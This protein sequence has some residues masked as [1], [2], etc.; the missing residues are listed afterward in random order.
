MSLSEIVFHVQDPQAHPIAGAL[1]SASSVH[2]PWQGLTDA[3]GN[4]VAHLTAGHYVITI[5]ASGF[6]TRVLPA[7]LAD[8]G[9]ITIGLEYATGMLSPLHA[10]R[11]EFFTADG[12]RH[13]IVGSTELML[14]WRFDREGADA[15]RDVLE[16]RRNCGFNNLR[17]LW[18]KGLGSNNLTAS[19][20]MPLG[21]L[22]PFLALAAE[23][24]FYI[25]GVILAD[26]QVVNPAWNEQNDRVNAVRGA[27]TG[28]TNNI[29]ELGNEF[30]KNGFDPARFA[31]PHDRLAANASNTE[32]GA[33]APYWDFF[34]FSGRRSPVQAAIREYGPIEF[35]YGDRATWGGLPVICD[36]GF[37][38]GQQSSDPRDFERAGAQARSCNG[39]RFHSDAGTAGN[40]RLFT[41]LEFAC[42][43]AFVKG[44][45]G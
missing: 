4:F 43:T 5:T 39:G 40:S 38:P 42:A 10:G 29:E 27:T 1:L 20:Q 3:A 2:G 7:D 41:P 22:R 17:V 28:V 32:G 16:E 13:L 26:C 24:R 14:A 37:K 31:K 33:D 11:W 44:M 15:I 35:L 8:P 25:E 19:W 21:K 12:H 18:Q 9:T 36:E 23:Y 30:S 6:Q 34:C 45:I